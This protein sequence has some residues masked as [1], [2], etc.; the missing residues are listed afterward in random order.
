MNYF[1]KVDVFIDDGFKEFHSVLV[2]VWGETSDH[3]M[4]EAAETPPIDINSVSNFLDD[5]WRQ[6]FRSAANGHGNAFF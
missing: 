5:F 3:F 2:V 4:N 6:I 1:L